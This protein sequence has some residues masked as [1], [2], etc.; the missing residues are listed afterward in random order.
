MPPSSETLNDAFAIG[1][2]WTISTSTKK[3]TFGAPDVAQ[4]VARSATVMAARAGRRGGM[5]ATRRSGAG[6]SLVTPQTSSVWRARAGVSAGGVDGTG[7][8]PGRFLTAGREDVGAAQG[9]PGV[10]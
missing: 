6:T 4:S 8:S 5:V 7:P 3:L 9:A 1:P 2:P 10:D